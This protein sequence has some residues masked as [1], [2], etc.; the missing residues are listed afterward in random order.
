MNSLQVTYTGKIIEFNYYFKMKINKEFKENFKDKFTSV[1]AWVMVYTFPAM[2]FYGWYIKF[3]NGHTEAR[4]RNKETEKMWVT[5]D[6]NVEIQKQKIIQLN[7]ITE[8]YINN[9]NAIMVYT[10]DTISNLNLYIQPNRK[11]NKKPPKDPLKT[12]ENINFFIE[13]RDSLGYNLYFI[14]TIRNRNFKLLTFNKKYPDPYYNATQFFYLNKQQQENKKQ[15][16]I[17]GYSSLY[18]K[19]SKRDVIEELDDEQFCT[20]DI[21]ESGLRDSW[22]CNNLKYSSYT[23]KLNIYP[24]S[25]YYF[26][27][28]KKNITQKEFKK[29]C[30]L[31]EAIFTKNEDDYKKGRILEAKIKNMSDFNNVEIKMRENYYY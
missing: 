17:D 23:P 26:I 10:N 2:A 18:T 8:S 13:N 6:K 3:D 15:A 20:L 25:N 11:F 19:K 29:N 4:K 31:L 9:Y 24:K 12:I 27:S 28:N 16:I 22:F 7:T 5:Y 21:T 1:A 14:D 30:I